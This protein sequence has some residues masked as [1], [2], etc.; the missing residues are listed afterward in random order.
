MAIQAWGGGGYPN[1]NLKTIKTI[2][3][4][5]SYVMYYGKG[6]INIMSKSIVQPKQVFLEKIFISDELFTNHIIKSMRSRWGG[7]VYF[8]ASQYTCFKN[9]LNHP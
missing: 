7:G 3:Q 9:T 5:G 6:E 1:L 2:E 4:K 8:G